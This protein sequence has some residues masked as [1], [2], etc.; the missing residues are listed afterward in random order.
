MLVGCP[1]PTHGIISYHSVPWDVPLGPESLSVMAKSGNLATNKRTEGE[2]EGDGSLPLAAAVTTPQAKG[3]IGW[4][5]GEF[6]GEV[7]TT[8]MRPMALVFGNSKGQ[9]ASKF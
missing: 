8:G 2:D 4:G 6:I 9:K 5:G 7:S 3:K 1:I